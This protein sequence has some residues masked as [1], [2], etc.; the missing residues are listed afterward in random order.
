M[1][2]SQSGD[3]QNQA[4]IS[5]ELGHITQEIYKKNAELAHTNK[6]LSVLRK[7][8]EIILSSVTSLHKVA[9][10]VADAIVQEAE[11]QAVAVFL[12]NQEEQCLVELAISQTAAIQLAETEFGIHFKDLRI[13]LSEEENL[14]VQ[15]MRE[16]TQKVGRDLYAVYRPAFTIDQTARLEELERVRTILVIPLVVREQLIGIMA[17]SLEQ[18]EANLTDFQ[19]DL[20]TRLTG[21]VGIAMD[22]ALLYRQIEQANEKLKQLDRL[23]D[24]FVSLASHELRTPMTAIK[25]YLWMALAGKGGELTEKQKYYIHRSY[26]STERLIKLVNEMLNVSRIESGRITLDVH[27]IDMNT[28][29][30]DVFEELKPRVQELGLN[31]KVDHISLPQVLA[32]TDKIKE[33]LINLIGNSLKFT[34]PGGMISVSFKVNAEMIETSVSDTGK[35]IAPEDISKLFQKFGMIDN[36]YLTIQDVRGTGLGLY[37]SKSIIELLGGKIWAKSE[38]LGKGT[39]FTFSLKQFSEKDKSSFDQQQQGK[40]KIDIIPTQL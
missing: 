11:F 28:L 34:P 10:Q 15:V 32:D 25:S 7:L 31:L 33:V 19:R 26:D 22:N 35:G 14:L 8:D 36:N 17:I 12:I 6:T 40:E 9:Q 39:T 27:A 37:I 2:S 23:K 18:E 4:N 21:V 3:S 29:V 20:V 30:D 1:S 38:G 5:E 13:P 24:D 16:K